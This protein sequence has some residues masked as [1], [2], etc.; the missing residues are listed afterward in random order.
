MQV[1][2]LLLV[3]G[4]RT[5]GSETV[6]A[7]TDGGGS[8]RASLLVAPA[9]LLAN[10]QLEVARFAPGLHTLVA[11]PS[12]MSNAD[13]KE[14]DAS[15]LADVDLV[16]TSYSTLVR[17]PSLVSVPWRLA[18]LDEAQAIKSPAAR[19]TRAVKQVDAP[20]RIAL[21][22]TPVQSGVD[23]VEDG[24][25]VAKPVLYSE[26]LRS[27]DA[28]RSSLPSGRTTRTGRCARKR[29]NREAR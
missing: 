12:A 18:V 10:W 16:I 26:R 5:S 1:L 20:A 9:S 8:R 19:Q 28:S 6:T 29:R 15:R 11:H 4:K 22:G 17:T 27:S 24:P 2:A 13:L 3:L 7:Q 21:T 14:I 23:E 25:E